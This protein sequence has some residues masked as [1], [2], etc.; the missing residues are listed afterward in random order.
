MSQPRLHRSRLWIALAVGLVLWS[1]LS[2]AVARPTATRTDARQATRSTRPTKATA[3][4]PM[5]EGVRWMSAGAALW[6]A[7]M[8]GWVLPGCKAALDVNARIASSWLEV[9]AGKKTP[10]AHLREIGQR[11]IS[12][13]RYDRL[14]DTV[15]KQLFGSASFAG[16]KVLLENDLFKLSYIPATGKAAG[17]KR[18]PAVFHVGGFL[19]YGDKIFRFLPEKNL[20]KP[21][22]ERGMD[23]YAFELKPGVAGKTRQVGGFTL[24]K[25][26][27]TIDGF[28]DVAFKHNKRRKMV[29]EGYCGLGMPT[30]SYLAAKPKQANSKFSVAA[31]MVAPVDGRACTAIDAVNRA[32]PKSLAAYNQALAKMLG[33]VVPG[34]AIGA[35]IDLATAGSD[36]SPPFQKTPMGRFC[37]GWQAGNWGAVKSVADLDK[38]Q[39]PAL[40]GAYWISPQGAASAPMPLE[41]ANFASRLW[42]EGIV[43]GKIPASY[44]GKQLSLETIRDQTKIRM[45]GFYGGRDELVPDATAKPLRKAMGDRY[46]HVVDP[47][48]GHI[49]FVMSSAPWRA[50]QN[51]AT[52]I[53]QEYDK[54]RRVRACKPRVPKTASKTVTR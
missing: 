42:S 12:G 51:P 7:S 8:T 2:P 47:E 33:G 4:N 24:E 14:V 3:F 25:L 29:I 32:T 38:R 22:V 39:R 48:A 44:K 41:L 15:G 34:A 9:M 19:P 10:A 49:A 37:A 27:D 6:R 26:I 11:N 43:N 53:C 50:E 28:S 35:N 1:Q 52:V 21:L 20:F 5:L 16:E 13:L 18:A 30:I 46:R 17:R 45:V 31:T 54:T 40:A 23:V 36:K